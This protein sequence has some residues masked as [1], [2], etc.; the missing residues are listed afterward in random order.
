VEFNFVSIHLE[1]TLVTL[2]GVCVFSYAKH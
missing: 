1:V 2:N